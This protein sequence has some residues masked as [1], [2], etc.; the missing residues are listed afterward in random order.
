MPQR[1]ALA[2]GALSGCKQGKL[3]SK[4]APPAPAV[5]PAAGASLCAGLVGEACGCR[6]NLRTS[7]SPIMVQAGH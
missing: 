5:S 2:N 6:S 4:I 1:N 3:I 7:A